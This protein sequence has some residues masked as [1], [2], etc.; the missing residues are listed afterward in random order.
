MKKLFL[1]L[2]LGTMLV[3]A[4][5]KDSGGDKPEGAQASKIAILNMGVVFQTSNASKAA[6]EYITKVEAELQ[7]EIDKA[8]KG[9]NK[10]PDG[11]VTKEDMPKLQ[12]V[13]GEAQQRY[14]AEQQM[15]LS[16]INALATET[17]DAYREANKISVILRSDQA[18]SFDKSL[19]ITDKI[20]AEMNTK[21]ISFEPML[22]ETPKAEGAANATAKAPEANATEKTP[23][24][25]A[26]EKAP[27]ANS[28]AP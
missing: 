4:G 7:A 18:I 6:T 16:R 28:T 13:F 19:D 8:S 11:N 3:M 10:G 20:I 9:L 15:I 24:G 26:T 17:V 2:M 27:E 22:P 1:S 5:C 12:K 14:N 23:E 21:Q 25:N